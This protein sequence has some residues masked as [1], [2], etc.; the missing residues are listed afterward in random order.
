MNAKQRKILRLPY[1]DWIGCYILISAHGNYDDYG[2]FRSKPNF[3]F[4]VDLE[5]TAV[6]WDGAS[7][8]LQVFRECAED[9]EDAREHYFYDFQNASPMAWAQGYVDEMELPKSFVEGNYD[10]IFRVIRDFCESQKR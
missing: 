3:S 5:G 4:F 9:A 2:D 6:E 10:Y 7:G 1:K 8:P